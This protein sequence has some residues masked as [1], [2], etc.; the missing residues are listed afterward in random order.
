ML[1]TDLGNAA[2]LKDTDILHQSK[3]LTLITS[4][5]DSKYQKLKDDLKVCLLYYIILDIA[6][7]L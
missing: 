6:C 2:G 1:I 5:H 3:A 4:E 7:L